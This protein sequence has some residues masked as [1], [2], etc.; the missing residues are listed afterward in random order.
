VGPLRL[1]ELVGQRCA[2]PPW[3]H[4]LSILILLERP[5]EIITRDEIQKRLWHAD[6][7]VDF[8]H[9]LNT[10]MKKLRAVLDDTADNPHYIETIPRRL[11]L[12]H[13]GSRRGFPA[14]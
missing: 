9:G 3:G 10:A 13:S 6:T 2:A 7:F 12:R 1:A 8:E 4:A 11:S 5:G 14:R